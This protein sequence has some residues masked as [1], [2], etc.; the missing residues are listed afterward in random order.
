MP[1]E[2]VA[3]LMKEADH[4]MVEAVEATRREFAMIRT[5]RANPAVLD[6]VMVEYYGEMVP[7]KQVGTI[8]APEPRLLMIAP[9]D[10]AMAK[11][12][13]DAITSSD[14][15]LNPN[16]DGNVIRAPL[17]Q[18]T[19]E[20][21]QELARMVARKGEEGRVAVRNVRRDAIER[22]REMQ[23]AGKISEDD[24]RRFQEQAQKITNAHIEQLDKLCQSKEREIMEA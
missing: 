23:K 16:T 7:I 19:T 17:P 3:Q 6:R 18:L 10:K 9:W 1:Q 12:I 2:I 22:L 20:R 5:G 8:T 24:L 13:M 14:L 4:H 21:R 11:P 15:G